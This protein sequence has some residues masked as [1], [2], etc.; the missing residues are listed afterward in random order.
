M[1][2]FKRRIVLKFIS[3]KLVRTPARILVVYSEQTAIFP[4]CV[5]VENICTSVEMEH[6]R[7]TVDLCIHNAKSAR[8]YLRCSVIS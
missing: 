3:A 6:R 7:A 5:D 2:K 4:G 1:E 8:I